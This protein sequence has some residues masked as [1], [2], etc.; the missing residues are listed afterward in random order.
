MIK[1]LCINSKNK[2]E[3]IPMSKWIQEGFKY[4]ITHVYFHPKQGIQGASLHEVRLGSE[5]LP[6]E[7]YRLS[8]FA[9]DQEDLTKLIQMI[10]DCSELN[11]IDIE[12][13]LKESELVITNEN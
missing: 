2:P 10:E 7:S 11:T 5:S 1:C 9:I 12:K 3:E 4:H 13:M 6:Y 8:R